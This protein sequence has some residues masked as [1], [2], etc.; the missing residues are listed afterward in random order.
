MIENDPQFLAQL[1]YSLEKLTQQHPKI[2]KG[3]NPFESLLHFLKG[4][5]A[6]WLDHDFEHLLRLMYRIDIDEK[7]LSA[8][9]SSPEPALSIA[10]LVLQRE[11]QKVK[12]RIAY[13]KRKNHG[14]H[15]L[16]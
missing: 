15:Q 12:T 5:I 2:E 11:S 8:A 14:N 7:A 1:S 9:L 16:G 13:Q 4:Q 6:S 3:E 10:Q